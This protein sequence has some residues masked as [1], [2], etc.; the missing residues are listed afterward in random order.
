MI[1]TQLN[2]RQLKILNY[3]LVHSLA[4]RAQVEKALEAEKGSRITI[5]RDLNYLKN[6]SWIDHVGGGK[7]VKYSL[8][9]GKELLIPTDLEEYF[10]VPTDNRDVKY[11]R[12][13]F[14][15][16][17]HLTGLFTPAQ[18]RVFEEGKLKLKSKFKSLDKTILKRELERFTIELS[19][20]SSHIEGNTYSLLET[21]ELIKNK[22]EATGHDKNEAIMILNHKSAF[23][24]ILE[25]RAS[26]K[27][28]NVSDIRLIH[29]E[30][31]KDLEIKPG[32]R[33][34]AVG[35]TGTRYQPPDNKWQIEEV[36]TK[37]VAHAKKTNI[38]PQQ[39]LI[40]L[41]VISY[42]QPFTD[43]NKRTSR[44]VSNAILL[45]DGYCPLSYRSV[46][47]VEYKKAL[48]IFYEQ[49]NIFHLKRLFLEQQQFAIDNYFR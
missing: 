1:D 35:I 34:S 43:G 21:E 40:F 7:H 30:I 11:Q 36:L 32:I 9:P 28:I 41:A 16:I 49:N 5:I 46:D 44:M 42:L 48:I 14:E 22:K 27:E 37:L 18:L 45:A 33:E 3:L 15:L 12:F 4:S 8:K 17:D 38:T 25:H 24:T 31:I 6:L 29:S 39:A 10:L 47:E 2:N 23:D 13:N 19:W 20:K 26:F